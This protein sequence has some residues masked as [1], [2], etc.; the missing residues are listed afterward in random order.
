MKKISFMAQ[1]M[2]RTFCGVVSSEHTLESA[3]PTYVVGVVL[4]QDPTPALV[5]VLMA[6]SAAAHAQGRVH[7]HVVASQIQRDET[8][9]ND[10]PPGKCLR[11]EDQQ[12]GRGAPVRDHVQYRAKFCGLLEPTGC[13]AVEGIEET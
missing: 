13:V 4:L 8:L 7:V 6:L 12:T 9:E 10:A 2:K 5:D 11:Q 1:K 3:S